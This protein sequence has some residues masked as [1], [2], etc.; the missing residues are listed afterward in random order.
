MSRTRVHV[1]HLLPLIAVAFVFAELAG[2]AGA[3][4]L[5]VAETPAQKYAA[6]KLSYDAVL[7]AALVVIEDTSLPVNL[8]RSTQAAVAESGEL[9]KTGN[10]VYTDYLAARGALAAGTTTSEKLEV[11]T[12]NLEHWLEQMEQH[13]AR[14]AALA[15]R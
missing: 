6:V 10:Q 3:N 15:H 4:P 11:A 2:C 1:S 12:V 8:R 5:A 14:I 9:Y 7:S 13:V